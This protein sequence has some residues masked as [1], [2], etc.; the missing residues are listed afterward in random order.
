SKTFSSDVYTYHISLASDVSSLTISADAEESD[1]DIFIED[2]E[3][4]DNSTVT[5][6]DKPKT[7]ISVI[8]END[9][10][11]KTYVLIFEKDV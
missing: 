9:G 8:V 1:A 7:A 10:D 6:G 11:R 4:S 5:I 2:E 3:I